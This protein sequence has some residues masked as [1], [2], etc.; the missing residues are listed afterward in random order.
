[1]QLFII[2]SIILLAIT[3]VYLIFLINEAITVN[4]VPKGAVQLHNTIKE[5][6]TKNNLDVYYTPVKGPN[7]NLFFN[8]EC[9]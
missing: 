4:D 8:I 6:C 1:M 3:L 7:G 5:I 9:K 2:G